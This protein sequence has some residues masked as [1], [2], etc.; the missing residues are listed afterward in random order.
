MRTNQNVKYSLHKPLHANFTIP[1]LCEVVTLTVIVA[2]YTFFVKTE[3]GA[4]PMHKDKIAKYLSLDHCGWLMSK[5]K[6]YTRLTKVN[7]Y[8]KITPTT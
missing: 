3:E 1:H 2:I 4:K 7:L 6:V 5:V 8:T